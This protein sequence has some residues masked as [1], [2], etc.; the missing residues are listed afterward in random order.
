MLTG[1][2][3]NL[4]DI[5]PADK[6]IRFRGLDNFFPAGVHLIPINAFKEKFKKIIGGNVFAVLFFDLQPVIKLFDGRLRIGICGVYL[7]GIDFIRQGP[8]GLGQFRDQTAVA[9]VGHDP[10][11][12]RFGNKRSLTDR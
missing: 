10:V 4:M 1:K 12:H 6:K 3:K 11:V 2:I 5:F 9:A 7:S 8:Y